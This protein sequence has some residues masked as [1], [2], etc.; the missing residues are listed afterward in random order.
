MNEEELK[1]ILK[2]LQEELGIDSEDIENAKP[3]KLNLTPEQI[4]SLLGL[5]KEEM[6]EGQ[7]I[8]IAV[9]AS[10]EFMRSVV[11]HGKALAILARM[12][13]MRGVPFWDASAEDEA[14]VNLLK[15]YHEMSEKAISKDFSQAAEDFK[16]GNEDP[17]VEDSLQAYAEYCLK[18]GAQELR[19]TANIL[20]DIHDMF[21]RDAKNEE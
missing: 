10:R 12:N 9:H 17:E 13:Q 7:K 16:A 8:A 20:D 1:E 18:R 15:K 5:S 14:Q 4:G 21:S 19:E 6:E 3:I 11:G 2:K